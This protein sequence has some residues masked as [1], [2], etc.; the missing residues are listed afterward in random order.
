MHRRRFDESGH[1]VNTLGDYP[2]AMRQTAREENVALIDLN[3]MS[4]LFY[5]ALGPEKSKKAFVH[6]AAGTFPGQNEELKDDTHHSTYG[7][8]ELAR[9]VVQGIRT[10]VPALTGSLRSGV[11]TFDPAHP[12]DPESWYLPPSSRVAVEKPEGN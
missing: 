6:Y 5:E 10:N 1:V 11:G 12:D 8:Y 3:A 9:A 2:E 4:A 7:A